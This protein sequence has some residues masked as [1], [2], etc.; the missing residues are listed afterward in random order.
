MVLAVPPPLILAARLQ[1]TL[2]LFLPDPGPLV[3]LPDFCLQDLQTDPAHS[4]RGA[5]EVTVHDRGIQ[6][7]RLEDLGA[8]IALD[9]G[10]AHL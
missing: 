6:A 9:R 3:E 10:D 4:R 7:H 8:P 2:A 1:R 5:G